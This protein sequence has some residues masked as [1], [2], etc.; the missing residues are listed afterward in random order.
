M[1]LDGAHATLSIVSRNNRVI[2]LPVIRI[3]NKNNT[4]APG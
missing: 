1:R 4:R 3:P 2:L